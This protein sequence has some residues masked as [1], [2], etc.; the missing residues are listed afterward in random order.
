VFIFIF[1]FISIL[2]FI[3]I[4]MFLVKLMFT[5]HIHAAWTLSLDMQ[6]ETCSA[7]T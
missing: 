1:K 2:M 7:E 5:Q 6:H 4:Y 3:L